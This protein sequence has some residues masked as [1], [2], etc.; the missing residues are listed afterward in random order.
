MKISKVV[1]L[2]EF[3]S[4]FSISC[5]DV[6]ECAKVAHKVINR[7]QEINKIQDKIKK[8]EAKICKLKSESIL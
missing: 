2:L 7:Q 4:S 8:L 3:E 5:E 1:S 6:S